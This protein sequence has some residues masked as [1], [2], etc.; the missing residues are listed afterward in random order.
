MTVDFSMHALSE[1]KIHS[2]FQAKGSF[3]KV[4][5]NTHY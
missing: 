3:F 5:R 4:K 1:D 2:Y